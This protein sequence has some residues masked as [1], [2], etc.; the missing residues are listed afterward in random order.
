MIKKALKYTAYSLLTVVVIVNLFILLSGRYYLYSGIAKTYL[1]GKLGPTIYDLELFPVNTIKKANQPYNFI[2]NTNS[3]RQL[4]KED[5][6]YHQKMDTKAFLIFQGDTLVYEKYFDEHTQNQVS[7]SFSAAKSVIGMLIGIAIEEGKIRSVDDL[8]GKY[9][10]EFNKNG[11]EKITIRHLLT[12]SAGFDW[13]ESGA[14]PLSE[15]AEGYYGSDLY[16]LVT[17]LR[18][19]DEPGVNFNYQSGNSQ[20][21]GFII[22]KATGKSINQYTEE[23]LWVPLGARNNA[24]WS[25]DKEGGDE[26]AF[27]CM[28]ATARDYALLGQLLLN[29]GFY[30]GKQVVPKWYIDKMLETPS[31]KTKENVPNMRYGWHTWVY[32]NKGNPIYYCR[33]LMGQYMIAIPNKNRVIVRL[34]SKRDS[35]YEIPPSRINDKKFRQQNDEKIGH[36]IDLYRYLN[37]SDKIVSQIR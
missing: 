14:N 19:I 16:G 11:R 26:K 28:Y 6:D 27:C 13:V 36:T 23:K 8:A 18:V 3:S 31:M 15:A 32:K 17:R 35:H 25:L 2:V 22:E 37:M 4:S 34:G 1:R 30:N 5:L 21:L 10:P 24:Y 9:I 20:I 7:N 29:N 12:M 33:G